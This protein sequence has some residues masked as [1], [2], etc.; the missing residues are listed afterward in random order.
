MKYLS[1]LILIISLFSCK[2][3]NEAN[4]LNRNN[5]HLVKLGNPQE[6]NNPTKH[7]AGYKVEKKIKLSKTQQ[8][9][10]LKEINNPA[11]LD[12]IVRRC[13]FVPTY[14]VVENKKVIAIFD[15]EYCPKIQLL[16]NNN[17]KILDL[18]QNNPLKDL[19]ISI[20]KK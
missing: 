16:N 20:T 13:A 11:N 3:S 7:I 14:A 12:N 1:L 18:K 9:A 17:S 8:A 2:A 5:L 15:V 6:G 19:I 10:I 4:M